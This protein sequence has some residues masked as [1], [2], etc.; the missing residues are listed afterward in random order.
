MSFRLPPETFWALS[1]NEHTRA[2]D[3]ENRWPNHAPIKTFEEAKILQEKRQS[4]EN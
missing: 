1:L 3:D 2:E 4:D